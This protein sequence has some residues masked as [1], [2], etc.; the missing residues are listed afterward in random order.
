MK[1]YIDIQQLIEKD[2]ELKES[3]CKAF[4][5]GD[6]I[7]ITEKVDGSNASITIE[8]GVLKAF[9][10]KQELDETNTLDGFWNFVQTLKAEDF[11]QNLVIFGEWLRKNK[12]VYNPEAMHKWYVFDIY[13]KNTG[14]WKSQMFVKGYCIAHDL[15]YVHTLY[16]GPFI[17]WDHCR[18]FMNSPIYGARQE[19]IVVKNISKLFDENNRQPSYLKL[20][21]EDFKESHKVK[22]PKSPEELQEEARCRALVECGYRA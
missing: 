14:T 19:G 1:H 20:V 4:V 2:T 12:I 3:N 9:S 15:E 18:T 11:D 8:D 5:P 17:S 10:R 7:S 21:N 13:D 6:M 22:T 16:E